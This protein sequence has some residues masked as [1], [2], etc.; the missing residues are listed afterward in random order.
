MTNRTSV[1]NKYK[2]ALGVLIGLVTTISALSVGTASAATQRSYMLLYSEKGTFS[3]V[4]IQL[5]GS[6]V[7]KVCGGTL[8]AANSYSYTKKLAKNRPLRLKCNAVGGSS[9]GDYY[10]VSFYKGTSTTPSLTIANVDL[11]ADHPTTCTTVSPHDGANKLPGACP[12]GGDTVHKHD[13]LLTGCVNSGNTCSAAP[14]GLGIHKRISGHASINLASNDWTGNANMS[15][16]FCHGTVSMQY[17]DSANRVPAKGTFK[18]TLHY[19][20]ASSAN[21]SS[22]CTVK[23]KHAADLN[24]ATQYTVSVSLPSTTYFNPNPAFTEP[25]TYQQIATFTTR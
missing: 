25:R 2:A 17:K 6:T 15:K 1:R 19:H 8:N 23:F 4:K 24:S 20:V 16:Y 12:S 18:G 11:D 5:T 7:D 10:Q 14:T 22:H 13:V 21:P 3:R 9:N